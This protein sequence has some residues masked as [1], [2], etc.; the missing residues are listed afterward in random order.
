MQE[1]PLHTSVA[2]DMTSFVSLLLKH[3]A[4]IAAESALGWSPIATA[5]RLGH[6]NSIKLMCDHADG[7]KRT[8]AA[9]AAAAGVA[10]KGQH[11]QCFA[12]LLKTGGTLAGSGWVHARVSELGAADVNT[13]CMELV[14]TW[15]QDTEFIHLQWQELR[16][17]QRDC[18]LIRPGLRRLLL[19]S[20]AARK[21][22][23][24]EQQ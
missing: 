19:S 22:Q 4:D 23:C 20:L 9:L 2:Y 21:Q 1:T 10:A 7:S 8:L 24:E 18:V 6:T 15:L 5:A 16:R 13:A 12:L 17:Q 14:R 3:G 11:W